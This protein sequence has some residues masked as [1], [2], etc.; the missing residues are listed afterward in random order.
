MK[1]NKTTKQASSLKRKGICRALI[2]MLRPQR[3]LLITEASLC[4][5]SSNHFI[6]FCSHL[7]IIFTLPPFFCMRCFFSVFIRTSWKFY[8]LFALIGGMI[9]SVMDEYKRT[10]THPHEVLQLAMSKPNE[11]INKK[12]TPCK[13][14]LLHRFFP[15]SFILWLP[16][17]LE[18]D[19]EFFLPVPWKFARTLFSIRMA[20][21]LFLLLTPLSL[22][23]F[24][25]VDLVFC[26]YLSCKQ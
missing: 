14:F 9:C 1:R 4:T 26:V 23:F 18:R 12:N 19:L 13:L 22:C 5:S 20:A 10:H 6:A 24:K 15:H 8:V 16:L 25:W 21:W 2:I 7:R 17:S 11:M 3:I